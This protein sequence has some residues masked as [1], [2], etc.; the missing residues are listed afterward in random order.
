MKLSISNIAWELSQ[1][2]QAL[3]LMKQ[4]NFD[5]LE[6]APTIIFPNE[7]YNKL[8]EAK[9]WSN[10]LN[11]NGISV[12]SMQSI[13]YGISQNIFNSQ[14]DRD[15]LTEYTKKAI[16]FA[17]TIQ[18]KNLVFG[19]PKNRNKSDN[20]SYTEV[21]SFFKELGDYAFK[22]NT[23]LSLEP[24]PPIYGTNF[25]NTTKEAFDFV[26]EVNSVGFKVNIDFGTIIYNNEN[27][28]QL[29][30]NFDYINHIH[31]SEPYL[32]PIHKRYIHN[33]LFEILKN[34]KYD[35]FI[36]IEMSKT[37]LNTIEKTMLYIKDLI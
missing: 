5:G 25:I 14:K 34:K 20:S 16:D 17:S 7:P 2:K 18:C 32:T 19:C 23:T 1:N 12:S 37:D 29:E 10:E 24:N 3:D 26:K 36:S 15:F 22:N 9:L 6:I 4:Y 8:T 31:I 11:S 30:D 33:I 27:L 28:Q 21:L 35:K 13:W